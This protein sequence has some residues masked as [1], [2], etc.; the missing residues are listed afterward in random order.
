M[1]AV[2]T[3]A[4]KLDTPGRV[5]FRQRRVGREGRRFTWIR[6]LTGGSPTDIKGAFLHAIWEV[7]QLLKSAR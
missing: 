2:C 4:I 7:V 5:L 3:I 6:D 1:L